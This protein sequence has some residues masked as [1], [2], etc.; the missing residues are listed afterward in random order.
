VG[1]VGR[2]PG[3]NHNRVLNVV[4]LP[5]QATVPVEGG[6]KLTSDGNLDY[7]MAAFGGGAQSLLCEQGRACETCGVVSKGECAV[8]VVGG[9]G[10]RDVFIQGALDRGNALEPLWPAGKEVLDRRSLADTAANSLLPWPR[11]REMS[12]QAQPRRFPHRYET[13]GVLVDNPPAA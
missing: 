8:W 11:D 12:G 2:E 5:P 1:V 4:S 9:G 6:A 3:S 7:V 10:K 13:G